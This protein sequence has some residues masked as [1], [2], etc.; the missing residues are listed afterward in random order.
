MDNNKRLLDRLR[1]AHAR[2]KGKYEMQSS[3]LME[4]LYRHGTAEA[5]AV[6]D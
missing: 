4:E 5:Y 2:E 6:F 1:P 3:I